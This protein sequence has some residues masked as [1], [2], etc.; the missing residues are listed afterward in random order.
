MKPRE[1]DLVPSKDL[2]NDLLDD[3]GSVKGVPWMR[4]NNFVRVIRAQCVAT[5]RPLPSRAAIMHMILNRLNKSSPE[6]IAEMAQE[7]L[8]EFETERAK[9]RNG[10]TRAMGPSNMRWSG[11]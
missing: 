2:G 7:A 10:R 11:R 9:N 6:R 8:F 4:F 1:G 5:G 3:I